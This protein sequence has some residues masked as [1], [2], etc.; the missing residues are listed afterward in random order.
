[1]RFNLKVQ[2]THVLFCC[3]F[4]LLLKPQRY[5]GKNH[6]VILQSKDKKHDT[7]SFFCSFHYICHIYKI[8]TSFARGKVFCHNVIFYINSTFLADYTATHRDFLIFAQ[9]IRLGY[10]VYKLRQTVYPYVNHESTLHYV[11]C[12]HPYRYR[13]CQCLSSYIIHLS[14]I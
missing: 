14:N 11:Q 6:K 4:L 9:Y 3:V 8:Q 5:N 12:S 7:Y 13:V 1:M 10:R 2:G